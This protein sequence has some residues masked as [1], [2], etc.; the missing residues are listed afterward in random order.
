MVRKTKRH[1]RKTKKYNRKTKKYNRKGGGPSK[2]NK[3]T[4]TPRTPT[5]NK[6]SRNPLTP[7]L[8]SPVTPMSRATYGIKR[9]NKSPNV[10]PGTY[11]NTIRR[12]K[13][14]ASSGV[15]APTVNA[16]AP[17]IGK[18]HY[19]Q[20]ADPGVLLNQDNKNKQEKMKA[21]ALAAKKLNY[22]SNDNNKTEE[23]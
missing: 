11:N 6:K 3:K 15:I 1:N 18:Q 17:S 2:K 20:L 12:F 23:Y 8:R 13:L 10:P 14:P 4:K 21:A 9:N 22:N 5:I 16:Y 19:A 7:H